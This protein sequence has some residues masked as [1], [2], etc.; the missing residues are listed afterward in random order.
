MEKRK[1]YN[2]DG[3][4]KYLRCYE[5][6][7]NPTIDRFTIV[8]AKASCFMGKAYVGRALYV[9]ASGSPTRPLG[10]YQH[11]EADLREFRAPGVRVAF[12]SL[13]P[14]LQ[15]AVMEEYQYFWKK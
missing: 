15:E 3:S 1:L 6:K 14:A 5:V 4:P 9:A 8:F 10:F 7:R 12:S 11:G 13:P 2:K